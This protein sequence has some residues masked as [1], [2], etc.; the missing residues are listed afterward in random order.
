MANTHALGYAGVRGC[1]VVA[2]VDVQPGR[3]EAFCERHGI[4]EAYRSVEELLARCN[5]DA[6]SVVTTDGSHVPCALPLVRA[7]KHVLCEKPIA[8]TATEAKP[9]VA[10][11]KK[12]GVINMIN[13]SYRN[14][15]ALHRARRL[16]VEGRLGRI[17]HLE[18]RYL[19]AWLASTIWGDWRT[20]PAWLWR[21]SSAHG[22]KGVLGDIGVHI[23][24]LA[25]YVA[26]EKVRTVQGR[27]KAFPKAKGNRIGAYRLDAND[28]ALMH[29]E[30]EGG[31]LGSIGVTR[32]ATGQTN[33]LSLALYGDRGA[34]RLDLDRAGNEIEVCLGADTRTSRWKTIRCPATP[35]MYRRF[36]NSIRTGM[37]DDASFRRGW[38]VQKVLDACFLSDQRGRA[39]TVP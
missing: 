36:I 38:E 16:V 21:L 30:L 26:A 33:S 24:D 9:L 6:A 17:M 31:G 37:N 29:I 4:P 10:A 3:A 28:S 20:T 11:A 14:N 35:D 7:G 8:P 39:V 15:P 2:G 5:I 13:F 12:A 34:L 27:L 1:R 19:Q 25:T 23:V 22:S 32:W 18:A